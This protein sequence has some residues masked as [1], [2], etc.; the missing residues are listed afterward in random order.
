MLININSVLRLIL[1][2]VP[3]HFKIPRF[4]YSTMEMLIVYGGMSLAGEKKKI[5]ELKSYP[6]ILI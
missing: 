6:F 5:S 4:A 1:C 2:P 3:W